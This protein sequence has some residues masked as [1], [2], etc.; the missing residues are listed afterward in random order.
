MAN[1]R[2]NNRSADVTENNSTRSLKF[3]WR[4]T[5]NGGVVSVVKVSGAGAVM[6][7]LSERFAQEARAFQ[8]SNA[9][10]GQVPTGRTR[11]N[12]HDS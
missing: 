3:A 9:P 8:S 7:T 10:V 6:L 12:E 11:L 5:F 4:Q 2:R 1:A